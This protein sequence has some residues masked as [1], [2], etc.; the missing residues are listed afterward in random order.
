MAEIDIIRGRVETFSKVLNELPEVKYIGDPVLRTPS[1]PVEFEEGLEIG[2]KL[3]DI[4]LHYR[5]IAGYGRGFAA[6]QIGI[7]K[8]VFTTFVNDKIEIFINPKIINTSKTLNYY[9]ELCLSSGIFYADVGR[10][11]WIEIEWIN[12]QNKLQRN[13]FDGFLAR[14]YQHE[15]KHLQG[16]LNLDQ[17]EPGHI[18]IA[19]FDPLKEH[20]RI[21]R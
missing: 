18:G 12:D 3:G 20:L 15:E 19:T 11:D 9:R 17:C 6:P 1:L 2:R 4:L 10:P 8:S 16:I 21:S 13:K 5:K 7:N 14:L